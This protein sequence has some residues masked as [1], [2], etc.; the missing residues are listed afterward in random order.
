[1]QAEWTGIERILGDTRLTPYARVATMI[2]MFFQGESEES[3]SLRGLIE[4]VQ[5]HFRDS[6]EYRQLRREADARIALLLASALPELRSESELNF[7]A[8][9]FST[10]IENVGKS[11]ALRTMPRAEVSHWSRASPGLQRLWR[12]TAFAAERALPALSDIAS[13]AMFSCQ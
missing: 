12:R 6:R 1:M 10:V 3:P 9:L 4:D 8:D 5:A 2:E 13:S 7:L 11:I